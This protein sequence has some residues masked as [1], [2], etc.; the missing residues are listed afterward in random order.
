MPEIRTFTCPRCW[1]TGT[2]P[3]EGPE[4]LLV[5][6]VCGGTGQ[7]ADRQ[8][9]ENFALSEMIRAHDGEPNWP[10]PEALER[11][12]RWPSELGEPMRAIVGPLRVTSGYRSQHLDWL[13]DARNPRWL[14]E[15]SGHSWGGTCDVAPLAEGLSLLDVLQAG[16][17]CPAWDQL[18][19]EGG[20]VHAALLCPQSN[21]QRRQ[22]LLRCRA[23][24]GSALAWLYETYNPSDPTQLERCA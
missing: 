1:G 10:A 7:A 24:E 23:P 12:L 5:C 17:Q 19:I 16:M 20:C 8:V 15:Y 22:V 6:I 3:V 21:A 2:D 9:S 4:H 11:V 13:A 14:H 18:I